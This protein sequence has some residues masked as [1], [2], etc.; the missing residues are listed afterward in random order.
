MEESVIVFTT[1]LPDGKFDIFKF[2]EWLQSASISELYNARGTCRTMV[3]VHELRVF[4]GADMEVNE[5]KARL[6]ERMEQHISHA[7]IVRHRP[8]QPRS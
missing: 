4:H 6:Y 8:P 5:A 7:I 3:I 1:T 2:W